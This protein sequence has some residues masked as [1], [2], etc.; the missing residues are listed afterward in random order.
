MLY[1]VSKQVYNLKLSKI[2]KIYKIF[3]VLLLKYNA[4]KKQI[5]KSQLNFKIDNNKK[6]KINDINNS[7]IYIKELILK[8]LLRFCY[9]VF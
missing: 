5:N 9:L 4:I 7:T 2:L 1:S 3:Y 8:Y 6:Y